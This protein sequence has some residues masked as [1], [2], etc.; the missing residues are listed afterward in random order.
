[1]PKRQV[2]NFERIIQLIA[3]SIHFLNDVLESMMRDVKVTWNAHCLH[4]P[5]NPAT[6]AINELLVDSVR[7]IRSLGILFLDRLNGELVAILV[8]SVLVELAKVV[9]D[10]ISQLVLQ[11]ETNDIAWHFWQLDI[12][13]DVES[14]RVV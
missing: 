5:L 13:V 6:L 9:L 14:V 8:K 4:E 3:C 11:V 12:D 10:V 7:Y 2:I 1:M